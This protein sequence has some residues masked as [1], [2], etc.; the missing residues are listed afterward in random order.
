[1]RGKMMIE[2][3]NPTWI[4][5]KLIESTLGFIGLVELYST[6]LPAHGYSHSTTLWLA[7]YSING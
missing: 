2:Y 4:Q 5:V 6:G 3:M 1:M 7:Q